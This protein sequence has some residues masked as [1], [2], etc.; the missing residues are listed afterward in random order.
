MGTS[1]KYIQLAFVLLATASVGAQSS[2]PVPPTPVEPITAM[3]DAFRTHEIVARVNAAP[4]GAQER[5]KPAA[6]PASQDFSSTPAEIGYG[7]GV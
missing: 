7:H 2:V 4:G 5:P 3:L 1:L 6:A